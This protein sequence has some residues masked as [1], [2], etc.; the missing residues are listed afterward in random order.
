MPVQFECPHPHCEKLIEQTKE[1]R[2]RPRIRCHHCGKDFSTQWASKPAD[3]ELPRGAVVS[4][5][6]KEARNFCNK[7][8]NAS[9]FALMNLDGYAP[10]PVGQRELLV[11]DR[12][13]LS[14]L[15]TV[16]EAVDKALA[17]YRYAD[18]ARYL[19]EFAWDEFCSFYVEMVKVRLQDSGEPV[20]LAVERSPLAPAAA[21]VSGRAAV[22]R[23]LAHTLDTLLRLL[24]PMIPFLT[25]EVW[26]LLAQAAPQ[27]GLET[28]RQ[29][30][31]SIMIAPW[32][33]AD[34]AR[35][36]PR[37]EV[38]FARF[39]EV[40]RAVREIRN[41]QNV[42]RKKEIGFSVRCDAATAELLRPMEPYF[43]S[44]EGARAT[45]W[46]PGVQPPAQAA[47]AV[48]AGLEVFVDLA[49]LIDKPAEIQRKT[50]EL[51][52]LAGLVAAQKKKLSKESFVQRA[53]AA[54]VQKER[55]RLKELE[56][57]HAA[58]AAAL[59]TLQRQ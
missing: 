46:G 6:F 40:L 38:Q 42:A 59:E 49:D 37:I 53:P 56:D 29:A 18:A 2:T 12:W 23:I 33:E 11:E 10:G 24:H 55:Q 5:R 28:V 25:E 16:T 44:M 34:R 15:A 45:G 9:R 14:R 57:Q 32:P 48:S 8:W 17:T 30:E 4:D 41:R 27:R 47:N 26:Q 7:L 20:P 13:L 19:Y 43:L 54:V 36:D 58:T 51:E 39:Q 50:Q 22:Q 3:K 1:N 52:K 21:P 31:A 35:Q